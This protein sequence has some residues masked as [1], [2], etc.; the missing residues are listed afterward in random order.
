MQPSEI[1][2]AFDQHLVAAGLTFEAVVLGGAA[3]H[4]LGVIQRPTDDCDVLDPQIPEAVLAAARAFAVPRGLRSDW[5]NSR[6]HDFVGVP[7][8]LP[9]GWRTR[10]RWA[11]QG[12][13]L[14]LRTLERQDLLCTKLVALVDRGVDFADCVALEPTRAELERAWPFVAQYEGNVDSRESY[15]VPLARRYLVRLAQELGY[16]VVL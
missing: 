16:D 12:Q 7:G 13:A 14:R 1:I 2:P 4:L 10:L 8:C 5:L 15:W 11:Y 9:E 3:L 6:A